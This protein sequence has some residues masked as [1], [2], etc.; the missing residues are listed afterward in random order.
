MDFSED[1]MKNISTTMRNQYA[2]D[3]LNN[4]TLR[5]GSKM[6]KYR[7]L[8]TSD[9]VDACDTQYVSAVGN[10][11]LI[12]KS[13]TIMRNISHWHLLRYQNGSLE[14]AAKTDDSEE[15]G[16]KD[17]AY[18]IESYDQMVPYVS[19]PD[20]YPSSGWRCPTHTSSMCK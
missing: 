12:Q 11:Y 15:K 3:P 13:R 19:T 7:N 2:F 4:I 17:D 1:E 9:C 20:M 10:L 14:W 6:N 8:N 18:V 5:D 16:A